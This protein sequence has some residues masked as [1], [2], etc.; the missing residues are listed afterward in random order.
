LWHLHLCLQCIF[1]RFT[2][3]IILPH[4][5][6]PFLEQFLTRFIILFSHRNTK[7][8]H[9]I[10]PFCLTS[11]SIDIHHQTGLVLPVHCLF[12][13]VHLGIS[14]FFFFWWNWGLNSGLHSCKAGALLLSHSSSPFCSGYFGDGV[15]PELLA[16][17]GL[18]PQ[19]F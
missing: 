1:I 17:A 10:H 6:H 16:Q 12:R 13:G 14:H 2:P 4:P 8:I 18:K 19:T 3:S 15:S 9:H 11:P 5:S 7:Y